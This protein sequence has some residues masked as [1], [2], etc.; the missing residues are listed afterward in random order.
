LDVMVGY[1]PEDPLTARG[2]GH[3]PAS[4][5]RFLDKNGLKGAR[6]GVVRKY[7]GFSES[8]DGIM[9]EAIDVMK[10]Q[11]ATIVSRTP[12]AYVYG[13][14]VKVTWRLT[15]EAWLAHRS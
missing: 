7:F 2:V 5:E 6:I 10:K 14:G 15:R 1:D 3:V 11:G 4:Y 8:V 12:R 9:A 13:D